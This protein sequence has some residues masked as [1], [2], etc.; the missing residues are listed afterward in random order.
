MSDRSDSGYG[1]S[2]LSR[3]LENLLPWMGTGEESVRGVAGFIPCRVGHD[4]AG[5]GVEIPHLRAY[6][7]AGCI[8]KPI[9]RAEVRKWISA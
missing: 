5:R 6:E 9:G 3:R 2:R 1:R 7:L 8:V 4:D